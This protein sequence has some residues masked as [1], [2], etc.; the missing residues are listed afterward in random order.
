MEGKPIPEIE[1]TDKDIIFIDLDVRIKQI[2][3]AVARA[4]D[5]SKNIIK[6]VNH[7]LFTTNLIK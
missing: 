3:L 6:V 2:E 4:A 1:E 5:V 7:I